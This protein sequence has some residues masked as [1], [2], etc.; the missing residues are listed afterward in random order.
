[1]SER[2]DS[3]TAQFGP[4]ANVRTI[5]LWFGPGF[6]SSVAVPKVLSWLQERAAPPPMW[7]LTPFV[8]TQEPV[9][10]QHITTAGFLSFTACLLLL[11]WVRMLWGRKTVMRLL[12]ALWLLLH[13]G[14]C[15]THIVRYLNVQTLHPLPP[16]Q[17]QLLGSH[18]KT[19]SL[20][21]L[22]GT[23]LVLQLHGQE[24]VQ[25]ALVTDMHTAA[26]WPTGQTLQL[27]W[28]S[29]RWYGR[30]ITFLEPA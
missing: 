5:A 21:S 19:P 12:T 28:V 18:E 6:I 2:I 16:T 20:R 14:A 8:G 30:Y 9:N 22:G 1:V 23:L 4:P 3:H 13:L 7:K 25:Q 29:G 10:W 27:Q 15:A 24:M 11:G 26:Q 17:A